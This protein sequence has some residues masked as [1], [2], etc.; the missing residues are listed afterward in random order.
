[1]EEGP[2]KPIDQLTPREAEITRLLGQGK[3]P[4]VIAAELGISPRTVRQMVYRV[5]E[6][7]GAA[8]VPH[9]AVMAAVGEVD[10]SQSTQG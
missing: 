7:T 1:L 2:L 8:T 5:M 10:L 9:L 3:A 6:K 4:R